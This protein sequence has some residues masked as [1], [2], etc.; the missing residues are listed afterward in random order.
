MRIS[1]SL[2]LSLVLNAAQAKKKIESKTNSS[3]LKIILPIKCSRIC[4]VFDLSVW[5]Y[6]NAVLCKVFFFT[7]RFVLLVMLM[8]TILS[9]PII[10]QFS[11]ILHPLSH[12]HSLSPSIHLWNLLSLSRLDGISIYMGYCPGWLSGFNLFIA[13][14]NRN[15]AWK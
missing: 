11:S 14:K 3:A 7:F 2:S 12:F 5:F 8:L 10:C 4:S 13:N 15:E 1:L 6:Q 9:V